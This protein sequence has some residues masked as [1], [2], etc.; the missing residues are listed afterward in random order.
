MPR[1]SFDEIFKITAVKLVT[2]EGF[3]VKEVSL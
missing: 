1:R 3:S 2:E